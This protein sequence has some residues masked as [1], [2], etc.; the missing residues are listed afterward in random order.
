MSATAVFVGRPAR[1]CCSESRVYA[2]RAVRPALEPPGL[3]GEE[4]AAPEDLRTR[5]KA[6][7]QTSQLWPCTPT[8]VPPGVGFDL[9]AR[10]SGFRLL[11]VRAP[12]L[13]AEAARASC[14]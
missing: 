3:L 13:R 7:L 12:V 10:E 14:P 1:P 2:G 11:G 6:E 5:L 9:T 4:P 8:G